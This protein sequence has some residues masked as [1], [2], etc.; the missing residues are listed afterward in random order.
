MKNINLLVITL[1]MLASC[2]KKKEN[3]YNFMGNWSLMNPDS[4]YYE[5]NVDSNSLRAYNYDRS[6]LPKSPYYVEGDSLYM[7]FSENDPKIYSYGIEILNDTAFNLRSKYFE[8]PLLLR[9]IDSTEFTFDKISNFEKEELKFEVAHLNRRNKLFG[10][11]YRYNFDS[12]VE[13]LNKMKENK[14]PILDI[15]SFDNE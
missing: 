12:I 14:V 3:N 13:V 9:K 1:I 6:F 2:A 8:T 15:D 11:P 10:I 7:R 5:I 4:I